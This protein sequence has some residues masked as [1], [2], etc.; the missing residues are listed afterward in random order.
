MKVKWRQKVMVGVGI[1][2]LF[3]S[4]LCMPIQELQAAEKILAEESYL[5]QEDQSTSGLQMQTFGLYLQ[6]GASGISKLG[7]GKIGITGDTVAQQV[8]N[9]V[10]VIL[11]LERW[12]GTNWVQVDMYS[13]SKAND[14]YVSVS[15][16]LTVTRGYYYRVS[17]MHY[18]GTDSGHS[19][20]DGIWI[21]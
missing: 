3:F 17:G 5:T 7:V 12:D 8:V 16:D 10:E 15:R 9:K 21:G 20:S 1:V 19:Y 2:T 6:S 11:L 4:I 13:A 14:Y 18:A